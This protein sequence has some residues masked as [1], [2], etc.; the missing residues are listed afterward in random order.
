MNQLLAMEPHEIKQYPFLTKDGHAGFYNYIRKRLETPNEEVDVIDCTQINVAKNITDAWFEYADENNIPRND[1]SMMILFNGP[2]TCEQLVS[3][4]IELQEGAITYKKKEKVSEI[5][6]MLTV[7]TGNLTEKTVDLLFDKIFVENHDLTV[8][9][10]D[11]GFMIY[12][13]DVVTTDLPNDLTECIRA[14]QN[15]DCTWLQ[16]DSDKLDEN[17]PQ[18]HWSK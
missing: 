5:S 15:F 14:A 3:N 8:I 1:L 4:I 16:V 10:Y 13:K 6:T 9:P 2:K 11:F 12:C 17:L 18:Y 7:G